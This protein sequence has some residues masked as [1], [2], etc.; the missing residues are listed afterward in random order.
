M[1]CLRLIT[2][3]RQTVCIS[4]WESKLAVKLKVSLR[5]KKVLVYEMYDAAVI[6]RGGHCEKRNFT[7]IM[8]FIFFFFLSEAWLL[9]FVPDWERSEESR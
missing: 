6:G 4:P 3:T 9:M 2:N 8:R 7:F 5:H 1:P